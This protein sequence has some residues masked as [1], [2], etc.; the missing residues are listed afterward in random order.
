M[1]CSN[2]GLLSSMS[3]TNSQSPPKPMSIE[4]VMPSNHLILCHPF[5]LRPS[6][7]PSIRIF[8]SESA[9]HIRWSN[10]VVNVEL[11]LLLFAYFMKFEQHRY[12]LSYWFVK[13]IL[14]KVPFSRSLCSS[15]STFLSGITG[16]SS[17]Y[18]ILN[19][20]PIALS[21]VISGPW[22]PLALHRH[23]KPFFIDIYVLFLWLIH[24]DV[25][26]TSTWYCKAII[27][28]LKINK[29]KKKLF[30]KCVMVTSFPVTF[31]LIL[32]VWCCVFNWSVMSKSLWPHGLPPSRLLC[33]MRFSRQEHWSGLPFPSPGDLPD[34]G[35]EPMSSALQV[36]SSLAQPSGSPC[37]IWCNVVSSTH[38]PK[39]KKIHKPFSSPASQP[40]L[41]VLFL[42]YIQEESWKN[43]E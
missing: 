17:L 30:S 15:V 24:A 35:I 6:I 5:L 26:Q 14:F 12:C 4:S 36:Y 2:L 16:N 33:P 10:Q 1:D 20:L 40:K 25:C 21:P 41:S 39:G 13:S 28:Q 8:S 27:L 19:F 22:T 18:F 3:I 42:L 34:P 38:N 37:V 43:K 32:Y 11:W 31:I 9:L 29:C 23:S 7:P